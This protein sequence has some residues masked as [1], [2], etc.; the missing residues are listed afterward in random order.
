MTAYEIFDDPWTYLFLWLV[1]SIMAV[2]TVRRITKG[3]SMDAWN[4]ERHGELSSF[5]RKELSLRYLGSFS[6]ILGGPITLVI[7]WIVYWLI[8]KTIF[9]GGFGF[10]IKGI[11]E[12]G[13]NEESKFS[14]YQEEK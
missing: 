4:Y 5:E 2:P 11:A 8:C 10:I 12:A 1:L 3:W 9:W 14:N 6:M 7:Y 13:L